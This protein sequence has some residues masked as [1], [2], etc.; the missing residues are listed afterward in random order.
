MTLH[1]CCRRDFER[2]CGFCC[3]AFGDEAVA[4]AARP[5]LCFLDP[6]NYLGSV[7]NRTSTKGYGE[8][9]QHHRLQIDDDA[10]GVLNHEY[11]ALA[12]LIAAKKGAFSALWEAELMALITE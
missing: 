9:K 7:V 5:Y 2:G 8:G 11:Y 1:N 4:V 12:A 6:V 3:S 10:T